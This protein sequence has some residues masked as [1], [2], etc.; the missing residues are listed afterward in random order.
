MSIFIKMWIPI[1]VVKVSNQASG[2]KSKAKNCHPREN[3]VMAMSSIIYN[4][5]QENEVIAILSMDFI[6]RGRKL[7][8]ILSV[9]CFFWSTRVLGTLPLCSQNFK[10]K[11][12]YKVSCSPKQIGTIFWMLILLLEAAIFVPRTM[13]DPPKTDKLL[14]VASL[15]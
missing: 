10:K 5:S 4:Q 12:D 13:K 2:I 9:R 7:C 15:K 11:I 8:P 1:F 14:A 6:Y 3:K